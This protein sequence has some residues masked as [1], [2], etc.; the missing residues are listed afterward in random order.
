V[1]SGSD[2]EDP[3]G[4]GVRR[5]LTSGQLTALVSFLAMQETPVIR[6]P[7]TLHEFEP[8]AENLGPPTA[9]VFLEEWAEGRELFD[10]LGCAGCHTPMLVLE[11]PVFRTRSEVTGKVLEIDLSRQ[12]ERPRLRYDPRVN[13]YPVWLFSDMKRHD[14]GHENAAR[15]RDHGVEPRHYLTRRLW[16]LATS[17]PYMYDGEAAWIDAAI[18][19]HGGDAIGARAAFHALEHREK[20][21]LRVYLLSLTRE[22]RLTVIP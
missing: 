8:A 6:A 20:G 4:D 22:R 7:R 17:P 11:D 19:A 9:A 15:H 10:K 16:G 18:E 1:G 12:G 3:D 13:G 5:E 14:L 2:P 21:A